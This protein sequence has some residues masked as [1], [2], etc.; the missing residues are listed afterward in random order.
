[1]TLDIEKK[2]RELFEAWV[3]REWPTAPLHYVRDALPKTDPRYGEYCDESLQADFLKFT[4]DKPFDRIVMN[5][6]FSEG[7]WHAHLQ[8]AASMLSGDGRLVAILPASAKGKPVLEDF[9]LQW[10]AVLENQFAGTS[11]DVVI[12]AAQRSNGA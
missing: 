11:V 4:S 8:H 1:M 9:D 12:L 7:R 10:S 5:P 2:R 3:V 6:P